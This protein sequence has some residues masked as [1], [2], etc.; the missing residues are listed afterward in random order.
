MNI[1]FLLIG[2]SLLVG[3]AFLIGFFWAFNTGQF[4]DTCTP[5]M[6]VVD[7]TEEVEFEN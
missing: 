4:D 3:T 5:G 7:S 6:R 1:I 2:I